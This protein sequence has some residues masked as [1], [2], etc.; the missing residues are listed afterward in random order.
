MAREE[1]VACAAKGEEPLTGAGQK[2]GRGRHVGIGALAT[3]GIVEVDSKNQ[4]RSVAARRTTRG[5][6][7]VL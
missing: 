3:N 7:L 2:F 1:D 4:G 5:P 6:S